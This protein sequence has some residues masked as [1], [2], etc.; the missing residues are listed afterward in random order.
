MYISMLLARL[1]DELNLSKRYTNHCIRVTHITVLKEHSFNS[2]KIA[3]NT[4]HKNAA[5]IDRY[6]RKRR[7]SDFSSMSSTLSIEA[8]SKKVFIKRIGAHGKV[9]AMEDQSEKVGETFERS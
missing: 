2:M 1:S 9:T 4:G 8:T 3:A 6:N 5:S 7:D